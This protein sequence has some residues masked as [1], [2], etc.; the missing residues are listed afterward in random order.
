MTAAEMT[1]GEL[2][3]EFPWARRAL[4][5][6]FHIGGCSSCG[7]ADEEK[8]QEVCTRNGDFTPEEVLSAVKEAHE[9]DAALMLDPESAKD[10]KDELFWLDIR[11]SEEFKAVNIPGSVHFDEELMSD[12][13]SNWSKDRAILIVDH[14]GD[15][16]LDAAAYLAGHG[17]S[18][19][20]CLA[21]GIDAY[22][23]DIDQ[24]LPRYTIETA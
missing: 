23:R 3:H 9:A 22:S 10:K 12:M 19:V 4:F 7:F 1:M 6:R 14:R 2:L 21:G 11:T 16:A 13:M 8:L 5:Q 20:R 15:R 17:F 18:S 24:S